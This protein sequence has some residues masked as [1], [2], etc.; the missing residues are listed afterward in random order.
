MLICEM[1]NPFVFWF[2]VRVREQPYLPGDDGRNEDEES[3][4]GSHL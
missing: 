1:M 4:D 2:Q 3:G